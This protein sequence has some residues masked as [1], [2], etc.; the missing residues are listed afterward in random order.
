MTTV[1]RCPAT[2]QLINADTRELWTGEPSSTPRVPTIQVFS[3]LLPGTG[4]DLARQL[5]DLGRSP[6]L[7]EIDCPGGY[8]HETGKVFMAIR[9]H[10]GNVT[11]VVVGMCHSGAMDLLIAADHRIARLGTSMMIHGA[12]DCTQQRA[13]EIDEATATRFAWR[14]G[15]DITTV[16]RWVRQST[17]FDPTDALNFG[18]VDEIDSSTPARRAFDLSGRN[19]PI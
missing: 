2:G 14:T 11:A 17:Y 19:R 1:L 9:Q 16:R 3:E 4:D 12:W 5:A 13:A 8:A 7:I 6:V 15:V 10:P 18:V